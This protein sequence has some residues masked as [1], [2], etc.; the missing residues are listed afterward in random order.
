MAVLWQGTSRDLH[1]HCK[2]RCGTANSKVNKTT[3]QAPRSNRTQFNK[4]QIALI[5]V[6]VLNESSLG[7][8]H[9]IFETRKFFMFS[10]TRH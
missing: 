2:F 1:R 9:K 5:H 7:N 10:F 4:W 6:L 3:V 8:S